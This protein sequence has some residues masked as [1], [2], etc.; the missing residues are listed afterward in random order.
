MTDDERESLLEEILGEPL[1]TRNQRDRRE[2]AEQEA[3]WAAQ[4]VKDETARA[5]AMTRLEAR[6]QT[7]IAGLEMRLNKATGLIEEQK[8]F[9]LTVVKEALTEFS[10]DLVSDADEILADVRRQIADLRAER[11]GKHDDVIDLPNPIRPR[12]FQ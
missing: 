10:H 7:K 4:R 1:E 6:L 12:R 3:R 2:I 9:I 5:K 8:K 11:S